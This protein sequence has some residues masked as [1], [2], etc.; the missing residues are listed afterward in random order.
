MAASRLGAEA[1]R[2]AADYAWS[3][4]AERYLAIVERLVAAGGGG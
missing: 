2:Q 1:H 3:I 4:Q